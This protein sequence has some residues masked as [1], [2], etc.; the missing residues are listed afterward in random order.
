MSESTVGT[1]FHHVCANVRGWRGSLICEW[2][3]N[4]DDQIDAGPLKIFVAT[5]K[6][7]MRLTVM[8]YVAVES[9]TQRRTRLI[10]CTVNPATS[11]IPDA[12][13]HPEAQQATEKC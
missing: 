4:F 11:K 8:R 1:C 5:E 10:A 6:V 13:T 12:L 2:S 7:Q 9:V 3:T